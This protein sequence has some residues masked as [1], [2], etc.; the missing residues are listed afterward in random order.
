MFYV[1]YLDVAMTIYVCFKSI[2]YML[3]RSNGCCRGEETLGKRR[4]AAEIERGGDGA[5]VRGAARRG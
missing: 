5:A 3:Q 4:G 2:L 1:F